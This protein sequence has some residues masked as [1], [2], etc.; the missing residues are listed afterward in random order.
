MLKW[1][2]FMSWFWPRAYRTARWIRLNIVMPGLAKL[3]AFETRGAN[4]ANRAL[5]LSRL[6]LD[7][8]KRCPLFN[9]GFC[10]ARKGGCG[11]YMPIKARFEGAKC[12]QKR[13]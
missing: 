2:P 7:I 12:P 13:W 5:D 3:I 1:L 11:C 4:N 9:N 8:C 6:R 10:D